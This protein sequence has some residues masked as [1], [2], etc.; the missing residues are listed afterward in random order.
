MSKKI[1]SIDVGIKNLAYCIIEKIPNSDK[2]RDF[3]IL[4]WGIINILDDKLNNAPK[5]TNFL[6][7]RICNK[8]ATN[9][10]K[11][12]DDNFY[13]CDKI[14]C[15]KSM[16]IKY[17]K[18]KSKK[19]KIPSTKNTSLLELSSILFKKLLEIKEKFIDIDEVIIENQPVLK[20]PTM[21]SIQMVLYSYFIEHGYINSCSKINNIHL[22]SAR[23]KLKLYDGPSIDCNISDKYKK[24]KFLSIEYTK[25]YLDLNPDY[26][27]FFLSHKKQDDLADSFMQGYYYLFK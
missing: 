11:I 4:D 24:R 21:K 22:F 7:N 3:K 25:Y 16:K 12:N 17:P 20:N 1:V 8:L 10:I 2:K 27:D 18:N 5:C 23:N 19:I 6:K 14:T 15:Q 13:F 26:K 9:I